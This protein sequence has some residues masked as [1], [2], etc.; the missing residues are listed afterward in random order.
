M[1][2]KSRGDMENE[3]LAGRLTQ[4]LI[5]VTQLTASLAHHK[6]QTAVENG[7]F[8]T[9]MAVQKTMLLKSLNVTSL[10]PAEN[11]FPTCSDW[12]I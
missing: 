7:I 10:P 6:G 5:N 11:N 4:W 8:H 3:G 12:Y 2:D 1:R 9:S